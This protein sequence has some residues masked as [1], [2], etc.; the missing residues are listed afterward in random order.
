MKSS[1]HFFFNPL[2]SALLCINLYAVILFC[3]T[4]TLP[5]YRRGADHIENT[6]LILLRG[7][8]HIENTL[9]ILLRGADHIENTLLTLLRGADHLEN[10]STVA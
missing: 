4:N 8:D 5:L 1:C 10:T 7:A 3:T 2:Q 6:L 9:L